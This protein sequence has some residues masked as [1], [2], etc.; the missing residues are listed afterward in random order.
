MTWRIFDF[1]NLI[2][3]DG[4]RWQKHHRSD[5]PCTPWWAWRSWPYF[6][7][8]HS[9]PMRPWTGT[10]VLNGPG[11]KSEIWLWGFL[12]LISPSPLPETFFFGMSFKT[13]HE[14]KTKILKPQWPNSCV[15]PFSPRSCTH[16]LTRGMPNFL[17]ICEILRIKHDIPKILESGCSVPIVPLRPSLRGSDCGDVQTSI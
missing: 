6:N 11:L 5:L 12:K 4:L 15:T 3:F 8:L 9:L 1:E 16:N 13:N 7:I 17:F 10:L 14:I 2:S